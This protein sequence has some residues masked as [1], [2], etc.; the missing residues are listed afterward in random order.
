VYTHGE[1]GAENGNSG[2]AQHASFQREQTQHWRDH[3]HPEA[4]A[5]SFKGATTQGEK[6]MIYVCTYTFP[7][8]RR[9]ETQ[10]RFKETGG[11]PPEGVKMVGR[12]HYIGRGEGI[13]VAESDN[14]DAVAKWLQEWTDLASFDVHPALDDEGAMR[15]IS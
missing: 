2:Y 9:N 13:I 7:P 6:T 5:P 12:W 11:P 8:E 4:P 14:P 3:A 1:P 15:M 10:A